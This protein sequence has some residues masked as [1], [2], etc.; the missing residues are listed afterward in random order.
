[1]MVQSAAVLAR[2]EDHDGEDCDCDGPVIQRPFD[3]WLEMEK[4]AA[5]EFPEHIHMSTSGKKIRLRADNWGGVIIIDCFSL[6]E[7]T[8]PV[9]SRDGAKALIHYQP[10]PFLDI[11]V[12]R[13]SAV[14]TA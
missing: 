7:R 5:N 1:V 4:D 13:I 11:Y 10:M 12:V 6:Q 14:R 9:A 2:S 8:L 3:D